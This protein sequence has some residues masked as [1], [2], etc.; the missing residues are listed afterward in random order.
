M[1]DQ[2][3]DYLHVY[4]IFSSPKRPGKLLGW[5][6]FQF[7]EKQGCLPGVNW[8]GRDVDHSPPFSAE[9]EHEWSYTLL[10]LYAFI[11]PK[12]TTSPVPDIINSSFFPCAEFLSSTTVTVYINTTK[13]L[14]FTIYG[15]LTLVYDIWTP[16]SYSLKRRYTMFSMGY[17][18]K[19]RVMRCLKWLDTNLLPRNR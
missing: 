14:V 15:I 4:E 5:T 8:P 11:A 2:G 17:E 13:N 12:G 9:V 1:P 19:F 18:L 7:Q 3:F 10:P 16:L 6:S